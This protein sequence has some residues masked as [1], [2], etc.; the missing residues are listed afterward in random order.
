MMLSAVMA[1][2]KHRKEEEM[3]VKRTL[4]NMIVPIAMPLVVFLIFFIG[5]PDRF[6]TP[7]G[8]R[9]MLQQSV[10][11]TIIGFGLCMNLVID[12]W[13]FSAGAQLVLSGLIGAHFAQDYGLAGL[14]V[15]TVLAAVILG[16]ITGA[17]YSIFKIPSIIVTIGMM[18]VYE[19]AGSLYHGGVS[20]TIPA[21]ISFLGKSPWIFLVGIFAYVLAYVIYHCTK[22]GYNVRAV[23]NGEATAKSIGIDSIKIR[24]L[25][26]VIGGI[27][28][29]IAGLLQVSYGGAIAP[30]AGMNTMS[31]VFPPFM[32][33]FIGQYLER[34]C[35][36]MLGIFLGVFSMTIINSGLIAMGLPGTLQQVVTGSF[37]LIFMAISI[38]REQSVLKK[39]KAETA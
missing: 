20:I 10:I 11:N 18:L 5:Q 27:F 37:M 16:T 21:E 25:C 6:G 36:I 23:G 14:I 33:V 34:Y 4:Q 26:F 39:K 8:I 7:E 22:F 28:V 38:N 17:V 24:F 13:D 31:M 15:V 1:E 32:G 35:D 30:K 19:S 2:T 29:G 9:I 3:R 12:T